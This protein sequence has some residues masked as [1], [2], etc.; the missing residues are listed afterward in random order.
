MR[1][2]QYKLV[3]DLEAVSRFILQSPKSGYS[4]DTTARLASM[5]AAGLGISHAFECGGDQFR[6]HSNPFIAAQRNPF[7]DCSDDAFGRSHRPI[8]CAVAGNNFPRLF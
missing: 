5:N 3:P 7:R 1:E 8:E 4:G 6:R 2:S